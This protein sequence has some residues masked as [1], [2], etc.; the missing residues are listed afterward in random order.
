MRKSVFTVS[1]ILASLLLT[2]GEESYHRTI[3][4]KDLQE[5]RVNEEETAMMAYFEGAQYTDESGG[6]PLYSENFPLPAMTSGISAHIENMVFDVAP[7]GFAKINGIDL[8]KLEIELSAGISYERKR[9][10]AGI[11]FIPVRKNP[12]NGQFEILISFDIIITSTQGIAAARE[13]AGNYATVSVLA[14][15]EW[16]KISVIQTGIHQITYGDLQN[17]GINPSSIDPRHIRLYGNGG[18][19]LSESLT[20]YRHDDLAEN[21]IFVAGESDGHFDQQDYILFYGESPHKWKY[22]AFGQAFNHEQ[23]IYSDSTC[24]FLTTDLGPGKRVSGQPSFTEPPNAYVTKFT[25]YAC[26]EKD[27]FNLVNTGRVWYG[28]VFDVSTTYDFNYSFPDIDVTSPAYFRAYVAAKSKVATSFKFFNG[29]DQV[30][31]ANISSLPLSSDT[32]ARAY[33]GS[34]WFTPSSGDINIRIT[35]QKIISTSLGWLNY[36]EINVTRNLVFSGAQMSFRDPASVAPGTI[37]EFTLGNAGQNVRVWNVTDP[38]NALRVETVQSGGSQVFR[39]PHDTLSEFIAFDGSSYL[40][41]MF[42][43]KVEN[44]NLHGAGP[45]EMIIITNS[46]FR[47]QAERL[48]AYHAAADGLSVLVTDI[49][50]VYNEFSS[51][52]PDLTAIR[53]FMKMLYDSAPEGEEPEYLL[54]FGD[55][56]FDYKDVKEKNSNLVPT[57]EDDESLTIVYSIATD[58]YFGFLDG[59]GDNLLDIGIGR[60][61]VQ[62]IEQAT[63]AVDKVIHYATNSSIVMK[64]WRNYICFVADD[65]DAN[66]HL[67]QAEEMSVFI[68]TNYGVYNVDKIYVDAFPQISTPGGQRAPEVNKAINNRIDKGC[69]IMNYTG[70]GGEVGWGHERFLENSDINSWTNYDRMP[71]FITAT[72]EFSRYDDPDRVSAGEYAYLNPKGGAIA[73]FTTARATFGGSNFNLNTAL[74][75]IMFERNGDEFYCFGDLI[76]LAKNQGGVVDND[77]KFILLGDPALHLAYPRHEVVTTRINGED[78]SSMPDT[79]KALSKITVEGEVLLASKGSGGFKGTIYPIVFDKPSRITTLQTDPTSH[80]NTFELQNNILYK[81]KAQ[82]TDG[83]FSFTFIVPKDIAYQYG[84][85]KISYY[86]SNDEEDAHGFYRNILVGGFNPSVEPDDT[87]PAVQLYMNDELFHFG[88]LTDEN[89]HMLSF[90]SDNSGINTVGSGI[91]HDIVA[92]LDGNTEKPIIL[93]DFYEADLDSY[94][95]GTIRYPFHNL[96]EGLHTLSLK[97]WDV[98]NN[99]GEAYLEFFVIKS[100]KF[101]VDELNNYPNPFTEGTTFVFSHNQ[102]EGKL[103]VSLSVFDLNGQIVKTFEKSIIP[104]GYR[105]ELIYWNGRDDSGYP[106]S[107]GMYIYRIQVRNEAGQTD[108]KAGK[109]ILL[110]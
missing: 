51:G 17:M 62:T 53:D 42:V 88:G 55:A 57:W 81:G 52:A 47:E 69:L 21:S 15:G 110:K 27:L 18:G 72:C 75:D 1:F 94:T 63:V 60:F 108:G 58:D 77:K 98:F 106:L 35:Y 68:D 70:H 80:P 78:I 50:Q 101:I 87:G 29:N 71:I 37:A 103:D 19:M 74:F 11:S 95:R 64:D 79:L 2:A 36:F 41:V 89:P 16:Y 24:Y 28:E 82:V 73:M 66:L 39:L 38:T 67:N 7:E 107:K 43:K 105:S 4:W 76:R 3:R 104:A 30:M 20:D 56:S 109:L 54:L 25:D 31:S 12:Y 9:P 48:A 90:V 49:G 46:L 10:Y 83:K 100:E 13:F 34:E 91:G 40:P 5:I 61:P 33:I 45:R 86:A 6:L 65:E 44:Q 93:N 99:S 14:T 92:I 96:E 23:N 97:V 22:Q 8:V 59:P 84:F 102:A 32:F 26:H 85:G